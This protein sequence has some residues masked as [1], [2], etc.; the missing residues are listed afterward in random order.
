MRGFRRLLSSGS[1]TRKPPDPLEMLQV[2]GVVVFFDIAGTAGQR[3]WCV[4]A[5]ALGDRSKMQKLDFGDQG[6]T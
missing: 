2:V 4:L 1:V 5:T 6:L 3:H